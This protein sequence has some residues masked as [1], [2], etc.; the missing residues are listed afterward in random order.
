M[1]N[2]ERMP[3]ERRDDRADSIVGYL[4]PP[5]FLALAVVFLWGT[6]GSDVSAS[7][8]AI[9]DR[10]DISSQ[11]LRIPMTDPPMIKVGGYMKKCSECHALFSSP[12][13]RPLPLNQHRDIVQAHGMGDR[14][15]NCHDREERG[16]FALPGGETIPFGDVSRL[17]ATCHGTTYR[18]WELGMHGRTSGSWNPAS[19]EQMRLT[20]SECHDPHAPAFGLMMSLPGPETLRMGNEVSSAHSLSR[21]KRNPLRQWSSGDQSIDSH[22]DGE[23]E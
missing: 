2:D 18:D 7:T 4:I 22:G 3:T 16:R 23:A 13:E 19:G 6:R 11:P 15:Y 21:V 12:G 10:A 1:F 14:C 20:C 9:V 5:V 17:C 8:R